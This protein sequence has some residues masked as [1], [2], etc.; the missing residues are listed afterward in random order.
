MFVYGVWNKGWNIPISIP[1][2][3]RKGKSYVKV[4]PR[5]LNFPGCEGWRPCQVG[6]WCHTKTIGKQMDPGRGEKWIS[7]YHRNFEQIT[8]RDGLQT[9]HPKRWTTGSTFFVLR[10]L[11]LLVY[12][13]LFESSFFVLSLWHC[14]N[15]LSDFVS[16]S[17]WT[18]GVGGVSLKSRKKRGRGWFFK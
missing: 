16:D 7:P 18:L 12:L 11:I 10:L 2:S 8:P 1:D 9:R 13:S 3:T 4:S 15:V 6:W 5:C 14:F 17:V